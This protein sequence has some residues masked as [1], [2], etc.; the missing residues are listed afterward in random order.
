MSPYPDYDLC[1]RN[2]ENC[3]Q[4]AHVKLGTGE[5]IAVCTLDDPPPKAVL[6][7]LDEQLKRAF[8][9]AQEMREV[10]QVA[11]Q[12]AERHRIHLALLKAS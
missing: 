6:S 5:E 12:K 3:D 1:H 4:S 8:E 2:C 10:Q 7:I 11:I 9:R